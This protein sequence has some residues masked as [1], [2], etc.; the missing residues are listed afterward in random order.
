MPIKGAGAGVGAPPN[1]PRPDPRNALARPATNKPPKIAN[2]QLNETHIMPHTPR[3]IVIRQIVE[4]AADRGQAEIAW[5]GRG[6]TLP[7]RVNRRHPQGTRR[8]LP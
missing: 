4:A 7:S 2:T 5:P 3:A 8:R 1:A 6:G